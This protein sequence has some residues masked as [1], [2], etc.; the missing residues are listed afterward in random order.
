MGKTILCR[1][2]QCEFNKFPQV[3]G[4]MKETDY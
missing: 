2:E 1:R 4:V 3:K